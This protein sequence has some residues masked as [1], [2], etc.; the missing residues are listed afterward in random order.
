MDEMT[1]EREALRLS[2]RGRAMLADALL[3]SLEDDTS[4]AIQAAWAEEA[5]DRL[6]AHRRNEIEAHDGAELLSELRASRRK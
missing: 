1:L 2:P 5:E 4:R 6:A 3:E